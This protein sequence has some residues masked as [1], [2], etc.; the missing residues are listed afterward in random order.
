MTPEERK[1]THY[2]RVSKALTGKKLS[3]EHRQK[4]SLAKKGK[5]SS[6]LGKRWKVS[7]DIVQR[8][9]QETKRQW[10][11]GLRKGG[12][13]HSKEAKKKIGLA[14]IGN[15][16]SLGRTG[17]KHP[18]WK[19]G[20]SKNHHSNSHPEYKEWRMKVFTRD[21]FKCRIASNDCKG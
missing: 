15:K 16:Y 12:W 11:L 21:N 8:I 5:P 6:V 20:I 3:F 2:E 14:S 18:N 7:S 1:K 9:S 4:L 10:D 19:G 17:E 13:K